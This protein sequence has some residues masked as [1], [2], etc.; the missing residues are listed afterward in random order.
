[1]AQKK[2][3]DGVVSLLEVELFHPKK[4]WASTTIKLMGFDPNSM[5]D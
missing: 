2:G 1:M 3:K 5:I 4:T